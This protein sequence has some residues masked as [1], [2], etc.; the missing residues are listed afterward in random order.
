MFYTSV[1]R[2]CFFGESYV[3]GVGDPTT[4]GWV[5]RLCAQAISAGHNL[6]VYNCGI[7]GAT[8]A[9]VRDTWMQEAMPRF[10]PDEKFAVVFSYGTNDCWREGGAAKVLLETHMD[11]TLT[12][13]EAASTRWPTLFVGAPGLPAYAEQT[14]REDDHAARCTLTQSL[15]AELSVPYFDTLA[16]YGGFTRWHA[17]A[18]N[19]DG[20]HPGAGGYG[21]MAA[22]LS[23]WDA[24]KTLLTLP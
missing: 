2:I 1:M 4:Q 17:E 5:G 8:S 9:L 10:K 16:V 14:M 22:A 24:W 21:E 12:I 13:L 23:M 18:K 20:A 3:A 11:N 6:T 19:G 7:R 15:C